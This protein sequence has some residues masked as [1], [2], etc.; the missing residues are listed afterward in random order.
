MNGTAT[1]DYL[2][3]VRKKGDR[4]WS[5]LGRNG[6][7][8]RLRIHALRFTQENAAKFVA[9]NSPLNPDWEWKITG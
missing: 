8:N 4:A 3:K 7:T 2:I 6:G 9:E 1:K 5:F